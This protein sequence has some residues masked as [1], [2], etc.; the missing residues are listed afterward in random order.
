MATMMIA[1]ATVALLLWTAG[2][3]G[4]PATFTESKSDYYN[5]LVAGFREGHLH[6]KVTPDPRL[7]PGRP[8]EAPRAGA[9][10]LL[11]ASFYRTKYHLYFGATPAVLLFL[12]WSMITGHGLPE[13]FAGG[14][15]ASAAFLLA[16]AWL[17]WL[18]REFFPSAGG[19]AWIIVTLALGLG[20]GL[21]VVLRP[22][23]FYQIAILSGLACSIAALLCLTLALRR[24]AWRLRWLALG[25]L[26][27]GLAA[28]SRPNLIP[29]GLLGLAV[30]VVWLLRDDFAAEN[31]WLRAARTALAASV[32]VGACFAA[33][34]WYNWM[35]FDNPFEFGLHYQLGS[36]V[37][38]FSF[39]LQSLW[40]NLRVYYLTPPDFSWFFPY[41]YPGPKPVGS[42]PE[43]MHGMYLFVPIL[44]L[45]VAAA[46]FGLRRWRARPVELIVVFA[47]TIV[48][49]GTNFLVVASTPNHSDRYALDFHPYFAVLALL[50]VLACN[51]S[52]RKFWRWLGRVALA[53]LGVVCLHGFFIP[54]QTHGYFRDS[55]PA[56]YAR[57]ATAFNKIAWPLHRLTHPV[58]GGA[59]FRVC[60]PESSPGRL[61]PIL[62]A[63]TGTEVDSVLLWHTGNGRARLIFDHQGFGGPDSE[64]FELRPGV[65]RSLEVRLGTFIPPY[66]HPWHAAQPAGSSRFL[67]RV[68]LRL[69]GKDI[70]GADSECFAVSS[71]Q[72]IL[73][74]RNRLAIGAKTFGGQIKL[75]RELAPDWAWLEAQ[76]ERRGPLALRVM[77]PRDRFGVREPLFVTGARGRQDLLLINYVREGEIR[78]TAQHEGAA[79]RDSEILPVDYLLPHE[80]VI[81]HGIQGF[82]VWL[83]GRRVF[84]SV[85]AGYTAE[86]WQVWV[87]CAPWRID[88][89]RNRFGGKIL[90]VERRDVGSAALLSSG[91]PL[92]LY[93]ALPL[94]RAGLREP[95]LT[96]GVTGRGDNFYVRYLDA[97]HIAFGFD[98]WGVSCVE[99]PP[100]AVDDRAVQSLTIACGALLPPGS[101]A[102][103][104]L[105]VDLN[106]INVLDLPQ[107]FHP[108]TAAQARI[109]E[110]QIGA[111]TS[112][113]R[114]TGELLEVRAQ[115]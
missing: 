98:H 18:R 9:D 49:A 30:V 63:G 113:P 69:D 111:S 53:W 114:F 16:L 93:L 106:G 40:R 89:T 21:P 103:E 78:L 19:W 70:L 28:G 36:D 54:F 72:L 15:L 23:K 83:D 2:S 50:A 65:V 67:S 25:S 84:A 68:S 81:H 41:F 82:S 29:G 101:A 109:G 74:R 56:E 34:G 62:E 6:M 102:S 17:A 13:W 27:L 43:E 51:A 66:G 77:L 64:E 92:T 47:A 42:N 71:N 76:A 44:L 48:S 55:N 26:A 7:G 5:L 52:G 97:T 75:E 37:A 39:T 105:R 87:G 91:K 100:M 61:E 115:P 3:T 110:N 112:E 95:L 59:V 45:L 94:G 35:R 20:T 38:G 104:R 8:I 11:D 1:V 86:P 79:L 33:I 24:P 46:S 14:L 58:I 12:P 99:S 32:P 10:Y 22:A 108:T 73:G 90:A 107:A 85:F 60:F 96:T 4:E 80:F 88:T 31:K 57:L